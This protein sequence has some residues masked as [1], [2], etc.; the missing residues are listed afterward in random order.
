MTH[1]APPRILA[2]TGGTVVA[3]QG[4]LVLVIDRATGPLAT[5]AFVFGVFAAA[6]GGFGAVTFGM[7]ATGAASDIPLVVSAVFL[8]VGLVFAAATLAVV[9][10]IRAKRGRP[11]GNYRPVAVFDRARGVFTDAEGVVV[12][13]LAHV[14]FQRRMQLGSSSPQ[15]VAATPNGDRILK[16]G[17]PF[18]GGI[19]DLDAILTAAVHVR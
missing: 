5:T 1:A 2:E 13:P 12:A 19:G 15:L 10:R 14:Q 11:L 7:R 3:E 4:P 17:N 8:A 6:F 16:R 9:R 18:N